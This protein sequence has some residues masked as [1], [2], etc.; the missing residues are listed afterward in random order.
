VR[1]VLFLVERLAAAMVSEGRLINATLRAKVVRHTGGQAV[2]GRLGGWWRHSRYT[3]EVIHRVHQVLDWPSTPQKFEKI[4]YKMM[5]DLWE[6]TKL[7]QREGWSTYR[8]V[9]LV[10]ARVLAVVAEEA[11]TPELRRLWHLQMSEYRS[12]GEIL[13]G[14]PA[15]FLTV[16]FKAVG[17]FGI[18][19][20]KGL[21]PREDVI[22]FIRD[23]DKIISG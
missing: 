18:W 23:T 9:P 21:L 13:T 10:A 16:V 17:W 7:A 19:A 20:D 1:E 14:E 15:H 22:E 8:A 4:V 12:G 2:L 11:G 6:A 3:R 5:P